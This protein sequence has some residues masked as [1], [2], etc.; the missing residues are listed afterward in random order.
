[1]Q[2]VFRIALVLWGLWMAAP[3][4]A[5][6][7]CA[8]AT[9]G[10]SAPADWRSYCW[11]DF[12]AYSD[13]A[14][15]APGG[16]AFTYALSDGATL[17]FTLRVT[18]SAA[19]GLNA[20][21][22]PSWSGAA[23]GNTAFTGIPGRPVLYTINNA[24]TVTA[25][26][27]NISVTPPT[28]VT[29]NTGW[30]LVAADGES[31]NGGE[32]LQFTTN[33]ANWVQLGAIPPISGNTFP[34]VSNGGATVT[35]TGVAGTVGGYIFGSAGSPTTLTVRLTAGGLQGAMIAVRYAWVS[36]NKTLTAARR[37]AVDQFNY[38]V[39]AVGPGTTLA[40]G[41]STGAGTGPFTPAVAIVASGYPVMV[42][43]AMAPG[44]ASLITNYAGRL[45]C[46]NANAGSPTTMPT[47][48]LATTFTFPTLAYGD[49]ITCNFSNTP[50]ASVNLAVQKSSAVLTDPISGATNPKRVPGALLTYSVTVTNPSTASADA[51]SIVITDPLPAGTSMV[52]A[53]TAVPVVEFINGTPSSGLSFNA[54]TGVTYSNQPGGGPPYT[55][56][57]TPNASGVDPAVT[58]IRIAPTGTMN[59]ASGAGQ[60]SFT[61]RFRVVVR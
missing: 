50:L 22:A 39:T 36:V 28:G 59:A 42:S 16:Q 60:P 14:A 55:Y 38:R 40:S 37:N 18:S 32:S 11:L 51:N 29:A 33:G 13:A 43:E 2:R 25:T 31:T 1:M 48:V 56:V 20:V 15:R 10:G 46:T 27:S 24:S 44:S 4:A 8:T 12:S 30:A 19:T 45:T 26:L 6:N 57:P 21:A 52:V 54:A 61:V 17:S 53:P 49:A 23:V 35:T 3:A 47:N 5:Q 58:G 7:T 41:T 34:T 9:A